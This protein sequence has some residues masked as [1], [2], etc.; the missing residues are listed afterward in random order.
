MK[1]YGFEN[2]RLVESED[3][4]ASYE[5]QR[6]DGTD[7]TATL[8]EGEKTFVTFLYFFNLVAGSQT[9]QGVSQPRVVVIDDPI[10]SLDSDILFVVGALVKDIRDRAS[11]GHSGI[12]QMF[13]LTHNVYFHKEASFDTKR[14]SEAMQHESFWIL[15]K[16]RD[17][18]RISRFWENPVKTSYELLWREVRE[19][20]RN[21]PILLSN[22][23]RRILENYFK[24]LGSYNLDQLPEKFSGDNKVICKSLLSWINDGSHAALDDLHISP[25]NE[26]V[27]KFLDVFKK[28]FEYTDNEGHYNMMMRNEQSPEE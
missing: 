4:R 15:H 19:G 14:G 23:L 6:S 20:W 27:E 7:A 2:F 18:A 3:D 8:S 1:D 24:I 12:Q 28:I 22:T 16:H 10:S 11:L 21:D 25:S 17:G 5:I 9:P 13:I 26:M